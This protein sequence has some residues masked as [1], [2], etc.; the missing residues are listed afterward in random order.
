MKGL[1]NSLPP[2]AAARG[3]TQETVTVNPKMLLE[4][5]VWIVEVKRLLPKQSVDSSAM[6]M[7]D[8]VFSSHWRL[9]RA[10][11]TACIIDQ[12]E[13]LTASPSIARHHVLALT[14]LRSAARLSA[15]LA[16]LGAVLLSPFCPR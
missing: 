1:K 2:A 9:D 15:T 13:C 14:L 3:T 6:H 8:C 12:Y 10:A 4:T 11:Q 5:L 16:L 7:L